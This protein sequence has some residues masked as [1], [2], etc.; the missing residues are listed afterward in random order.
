[1]R[2]RGCA[3]RTAHHP[4]PG[5]VPFA[6]PDLL[7]TQRDLGCGLGGEGDRQLGQVDALHTPY[8]DLPS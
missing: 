6:N 4:R 8:K 2:S 3:D 7:E 1:M 5:T